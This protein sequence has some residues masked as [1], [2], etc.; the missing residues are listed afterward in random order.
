MPV[1]VKPLK[2]EARPAASVAVTTPVVKAATVLAS[3]TVIAASVTV[4]ASLPR[5]DTPAA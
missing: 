2:L 3:A 4:I 5:P 1:P